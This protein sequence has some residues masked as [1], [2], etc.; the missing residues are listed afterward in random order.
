[1]I[2]ASPCPCTAKTS[3]RMRHRPTDVSISSSP[4]DYAL[5][6]IFSSARTT[7]HHLAFIHPT[8]PGSSPGSPPSDTTRYV[9]SQPLRTI[10]LQR[11]RYLSRDRKHD[12]GRVAGKAFGKRKDRDKP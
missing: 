8:T 10:I 1:M 6:P 12:C 7:L 3:F 9:R 4:A 2:P 11:F 5:L